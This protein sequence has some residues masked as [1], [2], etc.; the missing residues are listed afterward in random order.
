MRSLNFFD[1][2]KVSTLVPGFS[3]TCSTPDGAVWVGTEEGELCRYDV[4]WNVTARIS[5]GGKVNQMCVSKQILLALVENKLVGYHLYRLENGAPLLVGSMKVAGATC[6]DVA[7][8]FSAI[9]I[10]C[11]NGQTQIYSGSSFGKPGGAKPR[12]LAPDFASPVL[13]VKWTSPS[14]LFVVARTAITTVSVHSTQIDVLHSEDVTNERDTVSS[15][16]KYLLI[17]RQDAVYSYDASA[18]N[19]CAVPVRSPVTLLKGWK[20][21]FL[22][23]SE[24]GEICIW[25]SL[26][27]GTRFEAFSGVFPDLVLGV[28]ANAFDG[29]S[30]VVFTARGVTVLRERNSTE[31]VSILMDKF[32]FEWAIDVA[33]HNGQDPEVLAEIYKQ[34][35]D[36]VDIDSAVSVFKK[37]LH[38]PLETSYVINKL[39]GSLEHLAEYLEAVVAS[40]AGNDDHVILLSLCYQSMGKDEQVTSLLKNL[41]GA[42]LMRILAKE[43]KFVRNVDVVGLG[44]TI[45][46]FP[47]NSK[48]LF[49]SLIDNQETEVFA[50][51][52]TEMDDL[53]GES[54]E[55]K[56]AVYNASSTSSPNVVYDKT[57]LSNDLSDA[58]DESLLLMLETGLTLKLDCVKIVTEL[59]KRD[60]SE[61]ALYLCKLL[62]APSSLILPLTAALNRPMEALTYPAMSDVSEAIP[63]DHNMKLA[64]QAIGRRAGNPAQPP[65]EDIPVSLLLETSSGV[66]FGTL[67]KKLMDEFRKIEEDIAEKTNRAKNDHIEVDKMKAEISLLSRKPIIHQIS[68]RPC[69]RCKQPL[70]D[71]PVILFRC[72]HVYHEHCLP[73]KQV[74]ELCLMETEHH[75]AILDQRKSAAKNHDEL[76]KKLSGAKGNKFDVAMA[77]LGHGLFEV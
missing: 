67:Q 16:G 36:S 74:C 30:V 62:G 27:S 61:N 42:T 60:K 43:P 23:Y 52:M 45:T 4:S 51:L 32:L 26:V 47:A 39:L 50:N 2:R 11:A 56:F 57:I 71:L 25:Y 14:I 7:N 9:A 46:Q 8:D 48:I 53:V 65:C 49:E 73:G 59:M 63:M 37:A 21:Y 28:C 77:Y 31:Q 19:V 55:F 35:G 1:K 41:P 64:A 24:N 33:E 58:P 40:S 22:T 44:K 34:Y 29:R 75:V 5:V 69:S 66:S 12:I 38:L 6:I 20:D 3:T 15:L 54:R 17:A 76:F 13:A 68:G 70:V 72:M 10:G 18:G